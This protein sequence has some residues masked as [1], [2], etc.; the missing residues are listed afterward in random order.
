MAGNYGEWIPD[1]D[2]HQ[3]VGDQTFD[4]LLMQFIGSWA[5]ATEVYLSF[6]ATG[7]LLSALTS[8]SVTVW[9]SYEMVA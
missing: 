4:N 7:A 6:V 3:A 2:V 5:N 1:F 8:G 9:Y